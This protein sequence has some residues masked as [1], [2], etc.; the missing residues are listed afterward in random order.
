[1]QLLIIFLLVLLNGLLAMSEIAVVSARKARL[2]QRADDGSSGAKAALIL[3]EDPNRFLSTVQIGITLVGIIAGAFGGA[4]VGVQFGEWL[5][6][7]VPAI[8]PYSETIGI[9]AVVVLTTYLSLV[10]GELVPKRLG[11]RYSEAVASAVAVPMGRVSMLFAPVVWF[12]GA[13]TSAVLRLLR[14]DSNR[15]NSVS[16]SEILTM[17]EQGTDDGI[18]D[19]GEARMVRGVF[20]LDDRR[21]NTIM[22]PRT[23]IHWL[24]LKDSLDDIKEQIISTPHNLYPVGD[25]SMDQVVGVIK[26]KDLLIPLVHGESIDLRKLMR[27]TIYIPGVATASAALDLFR[28]SG[29]EMAI[30]VDEHGGV[31]G[32]V[33][34]NDV[35]EEIVGDI[36]A[37][38]PD[39][40]TR[41]DGSL[42]VDGRISMKDLLASLPDGFTLPQDEAGNYRTLAGFVMARLGRLPRIADR[43]DYGEYRFEIMDMDGARIDRVMISHINDE[44]A[45]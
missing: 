28:S 4:T 1:M 34:A 31:D 6:A 40:V 11:L 18:F 43:F 19:S 2:Q 37:E 3:A 32:V 36:D 30:V 35:I 9:G 24:N 16:E 17:I 22:T 26:A 7:R 27:R 8:A 41:A 15:D 13:S 42:L 12:L 44:A 29:A 20:E 5:A 38:D 45:G 25:G 23:A 21:V 10:L 33:T 14:V 39:V